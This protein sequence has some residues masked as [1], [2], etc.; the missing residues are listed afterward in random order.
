MDDFSSRSFKASGA[1]AR[2]AAAFT[3][4]HLL[5]LMTSVVSGHPLEGKSLALACSSVARLLSSKERLPI[6]P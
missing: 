4:M 1:T 5:W 2:F 3:A 6:L